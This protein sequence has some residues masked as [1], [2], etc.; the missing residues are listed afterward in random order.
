MMNRIIVDSQEGIERPG[1]IENVEPFIA[2]I[3][4]KLGIENWELSV[5]FC[6]DAFI[7]DLNKKYRDIDSPTDVLSFEQGDEYIDDEDVN[8]FNAGDIVISLDTLKSNAKDF[9]VD[10]NDELKRLLVH[11]VL[12]LD[13][14][15]HEDN[16]PEQEMLQF[17]EHLLSGF[18]NILV[19]GD[20]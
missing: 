4:D 6:N 5:L 13:G 20:N 15:D 17:Q 12:H 9:S 16:S 1:W 2:L 19:Y 3:L 11:G 10:V 7:T 8:W 18:E 14:M